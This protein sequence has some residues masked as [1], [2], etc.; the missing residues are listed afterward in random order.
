VALLPFCDG[1]RADDKTDERVLSEYVEW[2]FQN[3]KP[4]Y[5]REALKYVPIVVK[6]SQAQGWDPLLVGIMISCES[7]WRSGIT[8]DSSLKERGLMQVHGMAAQGFDLGDP[9]Q[10]VRAGVSWLSRCRETCGD[11]L[12]RVLACYGSGDCNKT[13]LPFIRRRLRIYK[14][15]TKKFRKDTQ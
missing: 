2:F 1:A 11:E 3:V 7:T 14:E 15:M 12:P 8:A 6:E 10:E 5:T 4:R 13:E 9:V